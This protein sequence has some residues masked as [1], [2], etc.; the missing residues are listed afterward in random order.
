MFW[1]PGSSYVDINARSALIFYSFLFNI[2]L[3]SLHCFFKRFSI[4]NRMTKS[5]RDKQKTSL[6]EEI[7]TYKKLCKAYDTN[8]SLIDYV[9]TQRILCEKERELHELEQVN[10]FFF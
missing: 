6:L 2:I 10:N 4:F 8:D 3:S 7:E 5:T 1:N 9:K